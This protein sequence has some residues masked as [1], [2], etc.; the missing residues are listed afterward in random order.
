LKPRIFLLSQNVD[1]A[2][3]RA[4]GQDIVRAGGEPR[5][6]CDGPSPR[7]FAAT[8]DDD[9]T[10]WIARRQGVDQVLTTPS[11]HPLAARKGEG[12]RVVTIPLG[13][14]HTRDRVQIGGARPVIIAGP[15]A[16]E[17]AEQLEACA[18][19]IVAAGGRL[20]RGGAYKPRTSPYAFSGLG[21]DA[22]SIL[23][24]TA[25]RH[26]LGVVTEVLDPRDVERVAACADVLQIG[27][28]TMSDFALLREV[29]QAK[30]AILLKRSPSATLDEL[31]LA[32]EHLL[33]AGATDV[34]LCE[35]GVRGFDG[36]SRNLLDLAAVPLLK[37]RT[38]LPVLV[39]PSHG[40][41]VR[42]AVLPMAAAAIA[43]GADGVMVECHP[44]AGSARSDGPQA[45]SL[46]AVSRLFE[47]V[48]A[49]SAAM[50][51]Q[52]AAAAE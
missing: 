42:R 24:E 19:A 21:P 14:A 18:R 29:A 12:T 25:D 11:P 33:A 4:I 8:L 43:A 26:R 35:R 15:C 50:S 1:D 28:R 20:L 17:S 31:L 10:S 34:M 30:K 22:L 44:D 39:D 7:A 5:T 40:V 16:V 3:L 27:A 38:D 2:T 36:S 9:A 37:L 47:Q 32:A 52:L 48:A 6:L 23:R 49:V 51:P 45:I 13:G 46:E 41:G